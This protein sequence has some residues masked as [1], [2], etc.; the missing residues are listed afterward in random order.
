MKPE[1]DYVS[2]GLKAGLRS[3]VPL[4]VG[5]L[6][7]VAGA[8]M[9]AF[10]FVAFFWP[11]IIGGAAGTIVGIVLSTRYLS[12]NGVSNALLISILGTAFNALLPIAGGVL[13]FMLL[14]VLLGK[15]K[16]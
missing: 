4:A 1:K 16:A 2:I 12:N 9:F 14:T 10:A 15:D 13:G 3:A 8:M 6:I 5:T 11:I 7:G